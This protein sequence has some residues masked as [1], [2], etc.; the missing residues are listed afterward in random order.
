MP[1]IIAVVALALASA[2]SPALAAKL[3]D[4]ISGLYG[5]DGVSLARTSHPLEHSVHFER[6]SAQALETFGDSL[7]GEVQRLALLTPSPAGNALV[8]DPAS[9]TYVTRTLT[10]GP[11]FG[12]SAVSLGAGNWDVAVSVATRRYRVFEGDDLDDIELVAAHRPDAIAPGDTRESFENDTLAIGLD[13]D[14]SVDTL[15]TA[16]SYGLT[17]NLDVTVSVPVQ[18]VDMKARAQASIVEAVPPD[19]PFSTTGVHVFDDAVE[20]ALDTASGSATGLGDVQVALKYHLGD[21]EDRR[22]GAG[23]V[24]RL[25]TGDRRDLLGA[26]TSSLTPYAI[27]E[28]LL[29]ER[30][31]AHANLGLEL[32]NDD[33]EWRAALQPLAG[34]TYGIGELLGSVELAGRYELNGDDVGEAQTDLALGVK[35]A[36]PGTERYLFSGA[37]LAPLDDSGLRPDYTVLLGVA[38]GL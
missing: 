12:R 25:A 1:W 22:L 7:N 31:A 10:L 14:L 9:N 16:V 19:S 17:N 13:V 38:W 4:L 26:G 6:A 35:W 23:L 21:D 34:L 5:G 37:L 8:F 30:W 32:L 11:L 29:D 28:W 2:T 24:T 18:R 36:P 33:G 3:E 27:G 15:T 20:P